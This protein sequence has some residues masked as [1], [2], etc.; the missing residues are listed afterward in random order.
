[1]SQVLRRLAG[2]SYFLLSALAQR[3]YFKYLPSGAVE[4][5]RAG[6]PSND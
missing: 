1:M 4:W 2:L 6:V 3:G 5:L